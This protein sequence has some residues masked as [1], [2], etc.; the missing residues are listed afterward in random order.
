MWEKSD[1]QG[2]AGSSLI[3]TKQSTSVNRFPS[4]FYWQ[5]GFFSFSLSLSFDLFILLGLFHVVVLFQLFAAID[6]VEPIDE[7]GKSKRKIE[8]RTSR[9]RLTP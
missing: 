7:S 5:L 1:F 2:S 8:W 9:F 3:R 4:L 6:F